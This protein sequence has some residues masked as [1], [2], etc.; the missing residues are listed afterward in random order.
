MSHKVCFTLFMDHGSESPGGT[1]G[2]CC[3]CRCEL[4]PLGYIFTAAHVDLAAGA[5]LM[6]MALEQ[7]K[8]HQ[9]L[10]NVSLGV[11]KASLSLQIKLTDPVWWWFL[12]PDRSGGALGV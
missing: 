12:S 9:V 8:L 3:F 10:A 7:L 1:N 6:L 4:G 2:L 11:C 5:P